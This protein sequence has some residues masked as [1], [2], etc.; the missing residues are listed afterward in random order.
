MHFYF[1]SCCRQPRKPHGLEELRQAGEARG[2]SSRPGVVGRD[3]A[4]AAGL[5]S[6]SILRR[7]VPEPPGLALLKVRRDCDW[8]KPDVTEQSISAI[9]EIKALNEVTAS[10]LPTW[11]QERADCVVFQEG[12]SPGA[13]QVRVPCCTIGCSPS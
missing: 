10:C 3:L 5:V 12:L 9:K 2:F 8:N 1:P 4:E 11:L 13:L 7:V 6:L